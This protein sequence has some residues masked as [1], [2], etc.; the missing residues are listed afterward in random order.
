MES[1]IETAL[2]ERLAAMPALPDVAW[3]N[4]DAPATLPRLEVAVFRND[5]Q[6]LTIGGIHRRPG[7]LQVTVCTQLGRGGRD[8]NELAEDVAAHFP[9]DLRLPAG[10]VAVRITKAPAIAGGIPDAAAWRV[11]VS[12]S[13]ET[14]A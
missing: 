13:F 6:R 9:A 11:P 12:I 8:A 14:L 1:E 4:V 2:M 10:S 3:P 7:I 5:T